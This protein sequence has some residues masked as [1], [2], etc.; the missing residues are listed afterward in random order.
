MFDVSGVKT[1]KSHHQITTK[2]DI[3]NIYKCISNCEITTIFGSS[4]SPVVC[5]MTYV[6]FT[7]FVFVCVLCCPTHMQCFCFGCLRLVSCVP[8]VASFTGLSILD[9]L[10][11]LSNVQLEHSFNMYFA[12]FNSQFKKQIHVMVGFRLLLFKDQK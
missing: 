1:G 7:L 4:L 2:E 6:L 12:I 9:F 11:V 3:Y 8:N 5:R 10:S